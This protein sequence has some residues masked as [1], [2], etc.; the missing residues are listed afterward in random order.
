[1]FSNF[2]RACV[3]RNVSPRTRLATLL[4]LSYLILLILPFY[5]GFIFWLTFQRSKGGIRGVGLI[6]FQILSMA[7]P[8]LL[9]LRGMSLQP[10]F[11]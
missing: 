3:F 11:V 5:A 7:P 4:A 2:R 8:L 10:I 6:V 9:S 1:M